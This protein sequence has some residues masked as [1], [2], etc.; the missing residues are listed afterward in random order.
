METATFDIPELWADHH[1]LAIRALLQGVEG[2]DGV[3]ASAARKRLKVNFDP[4]A[5]SPDGIKEKLV[6]AGYTPVE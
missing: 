6:A 2:I 3:E 4:A 5:I 1:V